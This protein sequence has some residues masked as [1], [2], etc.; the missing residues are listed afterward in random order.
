MDLPFIAASQMLLG[1]V[2]CFSFPHVSQNFLESLV[3][4]HP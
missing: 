4:D 3:L 2:L 1:F